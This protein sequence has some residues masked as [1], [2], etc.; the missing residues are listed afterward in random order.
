ATIGQAFGFVTGFAT[1]ADGL[2]LSGAVVSSSLGIAALTG[3]DG[4]YSLVAAPGSATVTTRNI[5]TGDQTTTT[6]QVTA[7]LGATQ[8]VA[9]GPTPLT[10]AS[11]SP[12][13][14]S[15]GVP[16]ES[17]VR[18]ALSA[19]IDPA[20]IAGSVALSAAGSAI[21]ASLTLSADG[22]TLV[23]RPASL[24]TSNTTYQIAVG[25][26]LRGINGRALSAPGTSAFTTI[27]LA[28]PPTPAAGTINA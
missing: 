23:L 20:S 27:N 7:G 8:S 14:G 22:Q 4:R 28:P 16:L 3:A 11:I 2:A 9:V 5:A 15:T 18:V 21:G 6:V 25:G 1:G 26:S 12:A 19:P 24:L 17:V 13:A 10:I